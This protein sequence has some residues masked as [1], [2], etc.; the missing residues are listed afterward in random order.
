MSP[1]LANADTV[2]ARMNLARR[3]V[4]GTFGA[5]ISPLASGL[6][7]WVM[8]GAVGLGGLAD[9]LR[10]PDLDQTP[11]DRPVILVGLPRSGTTFLHRFLVENGVGVGQELWRMLAPSPTLQDLASPLLPLMAGLSPA[12]F[13]DPAIHETSL[14]HVETDDASLLFRHFDGFFLYA[15]ALSHAE[16]DLRHFVDPLE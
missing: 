16:E 11:I 4:G 12:R 9:R 8:R 14:T 13:H 15:F 3:S 5:W 2:M 6:G 1:N 10:F 7:W